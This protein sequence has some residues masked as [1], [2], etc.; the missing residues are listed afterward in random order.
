MTPRIQILP[1]HVANQIAA[2]EVVERPASV[3]KELVENALDADAS[4][5]DVELRNGGKTEIRVADDGMGMAREDALLALDRHATSKIRDA[6]DLVTVST[7]GFRG[8][9]LP[10]IAA[11]SRFELETAP[12]GAE[13]GTRI[14]ARAG[15]VDGVDEIARRPGTTVTVKGLFHNVP[16]RARFLNSASAETRACTEAVTLLALVNLDVAFR[17]ASNGRE[18][19]AVSEADGLGRRV[20]DLWSEEEAGEM[21]AVDHT[22]GDMRVGGL[23]QR[24]D[25]ARPGG[26]RRNLFVNGRPF[27]DRGL[28]RI[29]DE[30][31]RTTV[32][33]DAHPSFVLYLSVSPEAVD[34]NVHPAKAEVRFGERQAVE[35]AIRAGVRERLADME[36]TAPLVRSVRERASEADDAALAAGDR[37]ADAV[38]SASGSDGVVR[39]ASPGSSG[40]EGEA[41]GRTPAGNADGATVL[42]EDGGAEEGSQLAFFV[43]GPAEPGG[44]TGTD[45]VS[46]ERPELWQLHDAYVL[47]ATRSGLLII[48]QHAAH[49]RVLFEEV[50]RRFDE[51]DAPSQR[52]LFPLTIRLTAAEYSAARELEGLLERVGFEIRT[53]GDR[54]VIV[55]ASPHP[56]PYFDAERCFR[57]MIEELTHGS[58]LVN[59]ARNQHERIAK[60]LA[61]KGAVKA[62]QPLSQEEMR[63]LFDRL[64]ATEL[65]GHEPLRQFYQENGYFPSDPPPS[66]SES[67]LT[68]IIGQTPLY[69]FLTQFFSDVPPMYEMYHYPVLM[70]GWF[71][72]FFTA[73]N[74]LPVG[75]LD[76]GHILYALV[77]R[78]WH[79]LLAR[80]FVIVLLL[81][82]AIGF[83]RDMMPLLYDYA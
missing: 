51:G 65:P 8:E 17:V 10:S 36:S 15:R 76:G 80:G 81:S 83:L 1:D 62:G 11:V 18:L 57:E 19:L 31:Y 27:R 33:P 41:A 4:R 67:L 70:A 26:H 13:V 47:A 22:A 37:R 23:I 68:L 49:E 45:D 69:W 28:N 29:V 16:A 61:C 82:G 71:G 9:A 54:T 55:H 14:R 46:V 12:E 2:G 78:R 24:P 6:G 58:P 3:V 30:A 35:E 50:M 77:G 5:V 63:E 42:A 56:H 44:A 64:F 25:A 32:P 53:F 75:Q 7:L 66:E 21:V 72:L 60:S 39:P 73:L 48:D 59:S 20:A 40:D 43:A 34:M 74:L 52:L 38:G 79:R